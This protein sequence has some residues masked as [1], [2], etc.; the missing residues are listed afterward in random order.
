[1]V[2]RSQLKHFLLKR[3]AGT[4]GKFFGFKRTS[5]TFG[6][7]LSYLLADFQIQTYIRYVWTTLISWHFQDLILSLGILSDPNVLHV[8]LV[9]FILSLGIL[10]DSKCIS[11]M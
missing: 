11:D 3:T 5:G 1:M 8:R 10:P 9:D 2:S 6:E 7:S 4:F